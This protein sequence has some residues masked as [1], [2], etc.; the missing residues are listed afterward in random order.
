VGILLE[1][2]LVVHLGEELTQG[3]KDFFFCLA[4]RDKEKGRAADETSANNPVRLRDVNRDGRLDLVLGFKTKK[5]GLSCNDTS[6]F[7]SGQT[8]QGRAKA[9]FLQRIL[10]RR[11]M[12]LQRR[13]GHERFC[14]KEDCRYSKGQVGKGS[15][16]KTATASARPAGKTNRITPAARA[17]LSAK[18]KA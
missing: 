10:R 14:E 15:S 5:T 7:L 11:R 12:E 1:V 2:F 8:F 9:E 6:M 17:K 13:S 3:L 18:L 16:F 4:V